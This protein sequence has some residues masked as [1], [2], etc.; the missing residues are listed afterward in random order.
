LLALLKSDAE[1]IAGIGAENALEIFEKES[2][3]EQTN[4]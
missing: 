4:V 1:I 2:F 3:P